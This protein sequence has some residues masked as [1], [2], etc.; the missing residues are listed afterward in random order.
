MAA[1]DLGLPVF[2]NGVAAEEL[3]AEVGEE[4]AGDEEDEGEGGV[5]EAGV[6]AEEVQVEEQDAEFVE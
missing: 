2:G 3:G 5:A 1:R 4:V 6:D